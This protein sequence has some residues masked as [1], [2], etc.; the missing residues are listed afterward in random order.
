VAATVVFDNSENVRMGWA[1]LKKDL[2]PSGVQIRA[3]TGQLC[4]VNMLMKM[5]KRGMASRLYINKIAKAP[6]ASLYFMK[7]E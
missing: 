2:S 7:P 1:G 4:K 5:I 6:L 3:H